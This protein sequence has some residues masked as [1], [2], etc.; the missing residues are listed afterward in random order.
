MARKFSKWLRLDNSAKIFPMM[1]NKNEQN[2]FCLAFRLYDEVEPAVLN[3]ALVATIKRFPSLNVKLKKGV[4]WHYF[5]EHTGKPHVYEASPVALRRISPRN[6]NGFYFRISYFGNNIYGEFFHALTDGKGASEFMKS[7]LFTYF[8]MLGK[9]VDGEQLVLTVNSPPNPKEY[10]DSFQTYYCK[11]KLSDLPIDSLKGQTA[12]MIPGAEFDG[13]GVGE[14][15]IYADAKQFLSFCR[16]HGGTVTETIGALFILSLYEAKIKPLNLPPQNIQL[17]VPINLR[18]I[19]PSDTVRNFSLFSRIGVKSSDDMD[20]DGLI[21]VIHDKLAEDTRKDVLSAKI[22]TTVYAEKFLP[23]R[24]TPLFLKRIIFN[25]SN[26]FFG[27]H[28]KTATFSSVGILSLP[29]SFR[30]LVRDAYYSIAANKK[31]P[32]TV[33][34]VTTFDTICINFTRAITDTDTEKSFVKRLHDA[35]LEIKVSSNYWEVDRAL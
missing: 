21:R 14:I 26:L 29:T 6:C 30:P 11:K 2:L 10:E 15:N 18:R 27:K 1:A 22:S 32:I 28:K 23:L 31:S 25:I 4:F 33:T 20:V 12:F 24:L 17:F 19:F 7:L 8:R 9:D 34:A 5:E 13:P 16:A 3:E 35:G